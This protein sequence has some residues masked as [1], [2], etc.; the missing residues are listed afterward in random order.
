MGSADHTVTVNGAPASF[1]VVVK[2]EESGDIFIRI[3]PEI[4][5]EIFFHLPSASNFRSLTRASPAMLQRSLANPDARDFWM[6]QHTW[7]SIGL[8]EAF[9]AHRV[10]F[11]RKTKGLWF[12]MHIKGFLEF[13]VRRFMA[14]HI[15]DQINAKIEWVYGSCTKADVDE[16]VNFHRSVVRPIQRWE[17]QQWV[18]QLRQRQKWEM[19]QWGRQMQGPRREDRIPRSALYNFEIWC[20]WH[21]NGRYT[22]GKPL[23]ATTHHLHEF[24]RVRRFEG[25]D[26]RDLYESLLRVVRLAKDV[27]NT[28]LL[29]FIDTHA[30]S[31]R[32]SGGPETEPR[33]REWY[34]Y[35][36]ATGFRYDRQQVFFFNYLRDAMVSR[37]L[38]LLHRVVSGFPDSQARDETVKQ[39]VAIALR[40]VGNTKDG[41][42]NHESIQ[43]TM[44]LLKKRGVNRFPECQECRRGGR[45]TKWHGDR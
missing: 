31:M 21:G 24:I 10:T 29:E 8:L 23:R 18:T 42:S 44:E 16:M 37:G 30:K 20:N 2:R 14:D 6:L 1:T 3:P 7:G 15:T 9:T 39:E 22:L 45:S 28:L 34:N 38:G 5:D 4:R 35:L 19:Q 43:R 26:P 13:D 32:E 33:Q 40:A 11:L 12:G 27:Y 17:T 41:F 25:I 36:P